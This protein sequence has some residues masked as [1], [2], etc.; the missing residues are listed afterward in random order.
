MTNTVLVTGGA[1]FVASWCVAELLK[2]DYVVRATL[3][4][5]SRAER[6]R[7]ALAPET[8]AKGELAF[9]AA[10]LTEDAGW[11]SAMEG[12]DYVLHV[13][14]PLGGAVRGDLIAPAREGT[15]RVLG[16]AAKAKV[17]RVVM[18]SAAAAARAPLAS[19]AVNDESVWADP[20]DPQFD[21]YRR[22]KILAE[23]AAWDF[24]HA[25]GGAMQF[26]AILPGAVFGPVLLKENLGSAAIIQGLLNGRPSGAPRLGFW[27]VDVRDLAAL[28]I[29]AMIAPE[30]AGERFIA[31]GE[32]MW[33]KD[34]AAV[35]RARLG[36]A[37]AK[38]PQRELP[39]FAVRVSSLF[40]ANLRQITPL[41]GK[42]IAQSSDKARRV[43]GFSPRPAAET[44]VACAQS[45]LTR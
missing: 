5:L 1:G 35:L 2:Q 12:V 36:D 45:L 33:M 14:S 22:S 10:D 41:L 40:A 43:L 19:K 7:Q 27:V 42:Q 13:A 20:N 8:Q 37:A 44:V 15:L 24:I 21:A 28:H 32:F 11:D 17:K 26:T 39:D 25:E 31:A 9:V 29:R 38:A 23:R 4:D 30:A 34:I 3:R 16:A 18:T 6:I